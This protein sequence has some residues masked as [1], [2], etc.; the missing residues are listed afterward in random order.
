MEELK[1]GSDM[2]RIKK[3]YSGYQVASRWEVCVCVKVQVCSWGDKLGGC[4]PVTVVATPRVLVELER[5]REI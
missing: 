5:I 2:I 4:S 3:E 1:S